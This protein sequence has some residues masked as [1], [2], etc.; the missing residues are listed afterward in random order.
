M[1][2]KQTRWWSTELRFGFSDPK[3]PFTG[4]FRYIQYDLEVMGH[5][6][7]SYAKRQRL[8]KTNDVFS[9]CDIA[10]INGNTTSKHQVRP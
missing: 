7:N 10:Q 8:P 9:N 5:I 2:L 3:Y 4:I 6:R 1:T